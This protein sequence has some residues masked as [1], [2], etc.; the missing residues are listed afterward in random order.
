MNPFRFVSGRLKARRATRERRR[1]RENFAGVTVEIA[2]AD[3]LQS[4]S[5]PTG[6]YLR[7]CHFFDREL[8]E[9]FRRHREYFAQ[10]R[11]GFGEDAFH[12]M[13]F[14]LFREFRPESFLEIGVFRGQSQSLAAMLARH[15]KLNCLVQGISPFSPAGDA[16]TKYRGDVNY[17]DD[18]LKNFAHF[19]LPVPGLLKA[20]STDATAGKLVAS[21]A[22]ADAALKWWERIRTGDL[23]SDRD[24]LKRR[25]NLQHF[26][27]NFIGHLARLDISS[28]RN[29][30]TGRQSAV[31]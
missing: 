16:I 18:T 23:A 4:L 29:S 12:A 28:R 13:W 10:N 11:R 26:E 19:S 2:R 20:F 3:W 21:R 15:F 31:R 6:F 9:E 22:L 7:C 1:L 25:L 24:E 27:D 5:D 30:A 17:F 8:P 14:L